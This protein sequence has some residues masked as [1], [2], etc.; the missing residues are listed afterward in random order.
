MDILEDHIFFNRMEQTKYKKKK[1]LDCSSM[2]FAWLKCH[3]TIPDYTHPS[4]CGLQFRAW[5]KCNKDNNEIRRFNCKIKPPTD[6]AW[7]TFN[8]ESA[9]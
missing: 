5:Q 1:E 7:G 6:P 4:K 3:D 2:Y 8:G 9:K